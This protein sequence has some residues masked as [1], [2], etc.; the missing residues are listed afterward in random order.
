[1]GEVSAREIRRGAQRI[2]GCIDE[3]LQGY[4]SAQERGQVMQRVFSYTE[5]SS[6]LD[7]SCFT[8]GSQGSA[9]SDILSRLK[10]SLLEV[11]SARTTAELATK[12]AILTA[13]VSGSSTLSLRGQTHLLQ[14]HPQNVALAIA[15]RKIVV[16]SSTFKCTL[17]KRK[18]RLDVLDE[19][20]KVAVLSWWASETRNSPNSKEVIRK[21]QWNGA[22]DTKPTQ[23]LM[24]SQVTAF[25][26]LHL[27]PD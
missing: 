19:G 16:A 9:H 20:S 24:E 26:C 13:L 22:I 25:T 1:M 15:R 17:S 10:Q 6:S 8:V 2:I 4:C 12:H 3:T 18:Q 5:S 23:Y 14:V 27:L 7:S 21:R 11:K